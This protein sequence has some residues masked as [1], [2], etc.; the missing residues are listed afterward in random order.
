[1]VAADARA[2]VVPR[3]LAAGVLTPADVVDRGVVVADASRA[4]QVF[5]VH[6]GGPDGAGA[7]VKTLPAGAPDRLA[8]EL[9]VHAL[10]ADRPGL[11]AALPRLLADDRSEGWL[12]LELIAPG[13]TLAAAHRD[14]LGYPLEL[15]HAAGRA[16]RA[17]HRATDDLAPAGAAQL[18]WALWALEPAGPA[19]FAW[20]EPA[21]RAVLD[22]IAEPE[23]YRAALAAARLAWRPGCLMHGDLKW[24]NCLVARPARDAAP[25]LRIIDWEAAG[26]G[27]PAW[28]LGGLVQEYLG[29][30]ALMVLDAGGARGSRALYGAI[31]PVA[32]AVRALLGAYG[33][34]GRLV[35]R[36]MR[37]AGARLV[38]TS[39]EHASRDAAGARAAADTLLRLALLLLESPGAAMERLGLAE[40]V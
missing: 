7:A 23:R 35:E 15:A 27:D 30:A 2:A 16:L 1:M 28:D 31:D 40:A 18:P 9:R 8:A 19:A 29:Y 38:Q 37:F 13:A 24:D 39:L 11:R 25:E 20:E 5:L 26:V 3:L 22:G 32:D 4:N 21:L 14:A 36:S 34:G 10:A 6:V 33:A 12:A 17:V